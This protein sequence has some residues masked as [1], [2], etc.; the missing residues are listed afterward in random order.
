MP[1]YGLRMPA[2]RIRPGCSST[3]L[4]HILLDDADGVGEGDSIALD[5]PTQVSFG[6]QN[7]RSARY[8][9]TSGATGRSACAMSQTQA[10]RHLP[11]AL[12]RGCRG[13]CP[14]QNCCIT[15][16]AESQLRNGTPPPELTGLDSD[17]RPLRGP[18]EHAHINPLDLDGDGHLDHILV[19]A[20]GGL[21][22]G[23]QAAVRAARTTFTKGGIEPLRLALAATG[24]LPDRIRLPGAYGRRLTRLMCRASSWESVTPFVPTRYV[25]ARGRNTLEGQIRAELRSRGFPYPD[26]VHPLA[27]VP[28][29][30]S[31][32]VSESGAAAE[33]GETT[34]NRFRHFKLVRQRG[35][36]PPFAC[37]F[38]I[39][40]EFEHPVPGPIA[41]GYGSHFGLGLFEQCASVYSVPAS[42][43]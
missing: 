37:G 27:P 22:A 2:E 25:K 17:H 42:A 12:L 7:A 33:R 10:C 15:Q 28:R 16:S 4:R 43:G 5:Y 40:L 9:D 36:E 6:A 20:P 1:D 38:A 14:M 3:R 18:H 8:C 41:I 34:W 39:R 19:W 31:D 26:A 23:A 32:A 29:G 21:G 11:I 13:P 35:P 24:D 30:R